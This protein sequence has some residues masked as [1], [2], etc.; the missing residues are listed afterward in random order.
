M[1]GL[2]SS[3][4]PT[5]AVAHIRNHD[6]P[7]ENY[8]ARRDDFIEGRTKGM[9]GASLGVAVRLAQQGIDWKDDARRL[10][11]PTVADTF[12]DKLKSSQQKEG[13]MHSVNLSQAV[14]LDWGMFKPAIERWEKVI[15]REAPPATSKDAEGNE[16]LSSKFAEWMMGLPDGWITD[17]GLTRNEELKAAGNG[18]CPQQAEMA[19]RILLDGIALD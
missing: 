3:L 17:V 16:R 18:V 14:H 8:L 1:L 5:A 10:P 7:V 9:P 12:T 6:E 2:E 11:T 13:S 15:E 19:L 4:L